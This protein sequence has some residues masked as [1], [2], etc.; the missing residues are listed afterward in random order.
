MWKLLKEK[1]L[2]LITMILAII[3]IIHLIIIIIIILIIILTSIILVFT[4]IR[5]LCVWE[6]A[7]E[8]LKMELNL[9]SPA[10]LSH[11]I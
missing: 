5:Y 3:V 4:T 10:S 8:F 2:S 7:L 1:N 6:V 11:A 9:H